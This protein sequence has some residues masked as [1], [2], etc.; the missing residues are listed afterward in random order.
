M[1]N[2]GLVTAIGV[3][4][5]ALVVGAV[6]SFF[7]ARKAWHANALAQTRLA[8]TRQVADFL[9]NL[10]GAVDPE[11]VGRQVMVALSSELGDDSLAALESFGINPTEIGRRVLYK[12]VL[13][14][15]GVAIDEDFANQPVVQARLLAKLG[16]TLVLIGDYRHA[17]PSLTRACDIMRAHLGD[18]HPDASI[19]HRDLAILYHK[20]A[21]WDKAESL[22]KETADIQS[23]VLGDDH[24]ET[25]RTLSRLGLLY[26]DLN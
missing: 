21:R 1:R 13:H 2:K 20:Q 7:Q 14:P 3:S 25:L 24:R 5:V 16:N 19:V 17:E 23:Q 22:Y 26:H 8:E 18:R 11:T 12:S 4:L 10:V 6:A 15:A 9:E